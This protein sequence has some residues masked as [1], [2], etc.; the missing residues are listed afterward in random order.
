MV[1]GRSGLPATLT[2][3]DVTLIRPEASH[4]DARV[5]AVT[6]APSDGW[7]SPRGQPDARPA[8]YRQVEHARGE[9]ESR[10]VA[11]V[12]AKS[13][14]MHLRM[15]GR[16]GAARR[17]LRHDWL[18]DWEP[19]HSKGAAHGGGAAPAATQTPPEEWLVHWQALSSGAAAQS[20]GAAAVAAPPADPC[21]TVC[22][23]ANVVDLRS[24]G[25]DGLTDTAAGLDLEIRAQE[26]VFELPPSV[27]T[28]S[29]GQ[30]RPPGSQSEMTMRYLGAWIRAS[31]ARS[32]QLTSW[33]KPGGPADDAKL[34]ETMTLVFCDSK[35]NG[36]P[37]RLELGTFFATQPWLTRVCAQH[38]L[39]C[40][41]ATDPDGA[42]CG[43]RFEPTP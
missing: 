39:R 16:S 37:R 5:L 43:L 41:P 14:Q 10:A 9:E 11:A 26:V 28:R 4:G 42:A 1:D 2:R 8:N 29:S 12:D 36:V 24:S 13:A 3:L 25:A 35:H 27:S 15:A 20:G 33:H 23:M 6:L 17:A 32:M 21:C 40:T 7:D 22:L 19:L 38:R 18:V 34:P 31:G 30:G